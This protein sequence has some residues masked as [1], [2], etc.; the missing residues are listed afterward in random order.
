APNSHERESVFNSTGI[1]WSELSR[2]P[3]FD[4]ARFVPPDAMHNLV[5]GLIHTHCQ[6]F[7]AYALIPK[8]AKKNR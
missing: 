3:Y 4:L 1:R 2:L 8:H 7:S 5:L 6:P